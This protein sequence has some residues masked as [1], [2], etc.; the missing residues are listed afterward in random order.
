M[1]RLFTTFYEDARPERMEEYT[2]SVRRNLLN[3]SIDEV[4]VMAEGDAPSL[5]TAAK[6]K[7]RTIP[8][9]PTYADFFAWINEVA[10]VDDVSIIANTDISF[11]ASIGVLNRALGASECFAV[12]RWD[13]GRLFDRN[14]SQ[15][16]WVFR[17][18]VKQVD[19]RFAL[20][21][22]RCDNRLLHELRAAGYHVLNPAFSIKAHHEHAGARGEYEVGH[23]AGYV[24]PPYEYLWPHNLWSLPRTLIH[25][26]R[27]PS[28]RVGWRF[29]RRRMAA[30]APFRIASR[31]GRVSAN[32]LHFST[33]RSR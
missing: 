17:G 28:E 13:G 10:D 31:I 4:C 30:T 6:L 24:Q 7:L 11:D 21:V 12:A 8:R 5:P 16:W 32:A 29:D 9:R 1:L 15:D 18:S 3:E 14:D 33:R 22:P 27:W 20:G 19:G 2:R 23:A 25:N 26:S